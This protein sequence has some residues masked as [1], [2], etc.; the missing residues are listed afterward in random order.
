MSTRRRRAKTIMKPNDDKIYETVASAIIEEFKS[1]F[2]HIYMWDRADEELLTGGEPEFSEF[3]GQ[4][5]IEYKLADRFDM[6][7]IAMI[8]VHE[9]EKLKI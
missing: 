8:A 1:Q 7:K 2:P 3:I 6:K 5:G 4:D 9:Y